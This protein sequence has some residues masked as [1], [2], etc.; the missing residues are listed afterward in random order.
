VANWVRAY[1]IVL[2]AH[3]SS[4]RIAVGVD[5]LIYGWI[6]FGVVIG[7]MYMIG[8]RWAEPDETTPRADGELVSAQSR[9]AI[10]QASAW[11][12]ALAASVVVLAPHLALRAMDDIP[13]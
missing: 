11:L 10:F 5:H 6:F 3:L 4:N 8:R 1:L 12:T 2:L 7:L 13:S 9:R